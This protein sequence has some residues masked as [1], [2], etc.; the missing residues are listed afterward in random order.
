MNYLVSV[1]NAG[2]ADTEV[3]VLKVRIVCV[4]AGRLARVRICIII[5]PPLFLE[6]VRVYVTIVP[7]LLR[8][9]VCVPLPSLAHHYCL[10]VY[11]VFLTHA[12]S[13]LMYALPLPPRLKLAIVAGRPRVRRV[14]AREGRGAA[15]AHHRRGRQEPARRW[16]EAAAAPPV[17]CCFRRRHGVNNMQLSDWLFYLFYVGD[18]A[19][20]IC[21]ICVLLLSSLCVY[22]AHFR[23]HRGGCDYAAVRQGRGEGK[24]RTTSSCSV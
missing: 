24:V 13:R 23:H 3:A 15:G 2:A 8:V 22:T 21:V 14:H 10:P 16:V 18:S 12:H 5:M 17:R 4:R 19:V 11:I 7:P 20:V 9:F 6:C 1:A